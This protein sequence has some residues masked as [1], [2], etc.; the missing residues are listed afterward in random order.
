MHI[1]W[2]AS[3]RTQLWQV[4]QIIH[5]CIIIFM[6]I[7]WAKMVIL[8]GKFS[9]LEITLVTCTVVD[10]IG[11]RTWR[12]PHW[13]SALT[14]VHSV[15]S[16]EV[17]IDSAWNFDNYCHIT[18]LVAKAKRIPASIFMCFNSRHV[19]SLVNAF[20]ICV[21][22]MVE[23]ATPIWSP[24]TIQYKTLVKDVQ[25][26]FTRRFPVPNG[27]K[28]AQ[29][30]ERSGLQSLE[31]RRLL[32]DLLCY[33]I[34]HGRVALIFYV[35][36]VFTEFCFAWPFLEISSFSNCSKTKYFFPSRTLG[37]WNSLPGDVVTANSVNTFKQLI[38]NIEFAEFS[39]LHNNISVKFNSVKFLERLFILDSTFLLYVL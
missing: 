25:R 27:V 20:N 21:R 23:N 12:C 8:G 32:A 19:S 14:S 10:F 34:I 31:H 7:T 24:H 37:V 39:I 30:L 38:R 18:E 16:L 29:R 11:Q 26:S 13:W 1:K 9:S 28:Y 35:F 6:H 3:D 17:T 4:C 22:P 36:C 33:R 5:I 2:L 15:R